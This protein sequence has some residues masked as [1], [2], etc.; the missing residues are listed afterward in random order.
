[1]KDTGSSLLTEEEKIVRWVSESIEKILREA[2]RFIDKKEIIEEIRLRIN[3]PL[4]IRTDKKDY[5]LD[6][7]GHPGLKGNSYRVTS[8]D[9]RDTLEKMTYS[10]IYAAEEELRQGFLTLPGGHRVGISGEAVVEYDKIRILKNI[11]ALNIRLAREPDFDIKKILP[12]LLNKNKIVCHTLLISPPRAGKTTILRKLIRQLSDGMPEIGLEGQTVG[13]V[14]ERSEIA[15]MWQGIPTF[16]LGCRTDVLDRCPKALGFYMLIR[17]MSPGIVA[18]DELGGTEDI[19]A[20]KEAV[21]C[22]VKILATAHA[23]SPEELRERE[24]FREI[25]RSNCFERIIV[26]S[27]R[28]GPGTVEA[29]YDMKKGTNLLS[30]MKICVIH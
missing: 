29:V 7:K 17:S 5:F 27:R 2:F 15:G 6:Y 11:S 12:L 18:V 3:Q 19:A 10:S 16:D 23:D 22:G 8:N 14:D 13:V 20:L 1:M 30:D 21:R 25:M 9:L 26:L 4:I 24:S 28:K